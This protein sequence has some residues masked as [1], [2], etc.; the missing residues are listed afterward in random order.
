MKV[1]PIGVDDMKFRKAYSSFI[2]DSISYLKNE[3]NREAPLPTLRLFNCKFKIKTRI[4]EL[5][6]DIWGDCGFRSMK[7]RN[8]WWTGELKGPFWAPNST[9]LVLKMV[10]FYELFLLDFLIYWINKRFAF[11]A[12]EQISRLMWFQNSF[13]ILKHKYLQILRYVLSG[14]ML[15]SSFAKRNK[16]GL[17]SFLSRCNV[18]YRCKM[19]FTTDLVLVCMLGSW[20]NPLFTIISNNVPTQ[21]SLVSLFYNDHVGSVW[22]SP[23][24]RV[25]RA[26]FFFI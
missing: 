4:V 2:W 17:H 15:D 9:L 20:T 7:K 22:V 26:L 6:L 8:R 24:W 18:P 10:Y 19:R 12:G 16:A 25:L 11:H 13:S 14:K 5:W 21:S 23:R 1:D 3:L